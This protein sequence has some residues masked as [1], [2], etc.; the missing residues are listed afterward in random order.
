MTPLIPDLDDLIALRRVATSGKQRFPQRASYM[1]HM[2]ATHSPHKGSGLEFEEVRKYAHG[3]DIRAIDWR[4]TARTNETHTKLFREEKGRT[5]YCITD[6]GSSMQFGTRSTFKSTQA[7]RI[8]AI[9]GWRAITQK[10]HAGF[11]LYNEYTTR[12]SLLRPAS[13]SRTLIHALKALSDPITYHH[14]PANLSPSTACPV[15]LSDV[16]ARETQRYTSGSMIVIISDF[17]TPGDDL[18]ARLAFLRRK[19]HVIG[20]AVDDSADHTLPKGMLIC[21]NPQ[22]GEISTLRPTKQERLSYTDQWHNKREYVKQAFG[23]HFSSV[24]TTDNISTLACL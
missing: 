19:Y 7:A 11:L 4:V 16:L 13:S 17:C 9:F 18:S 2:G 15:S 23:S 10:D 6:T 1:N 3:D 14:N 12:L 22:T 24:T 20:I 21:K 5:I 8:A